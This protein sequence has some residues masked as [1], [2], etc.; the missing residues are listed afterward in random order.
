[1]LKKK[2]E[3][4]KRKNKLSK[5]STVS[6][7]CKDH[8]TYNAIYPPKTDC[9]VCWKIYATRM[10]LNNKILKVALKELRNVRR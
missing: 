4:I 6:M 7:T 2:K 10:R 3:I 5:K 1:M 9:I 8:V